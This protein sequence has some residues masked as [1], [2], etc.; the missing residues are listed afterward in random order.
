MAIPYGKRLSLIGHQGNKNHN[1]I[2]WHIYQ[3][4]YECWKETKCSWGCKELKLQYL[5][6]WEN[7]WVQPFCKTAW[8]SSTEAKHVSTYGLSH[9]TAMYL[10]D[11]DESVHSP[12]E[13]YK[14]IHVPFIT[15][16]NCKSFKCPS[17]VK[18]TIQLIYAVRILHILYIAGCT[19]DLN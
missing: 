19:V 17:Q 5:A 8:Q 4:A 14:D 18:W 12:K 11:T 10:P 16:S 3:N 1:E 7:K 13:M 15:V 9:C 2:S 6:E